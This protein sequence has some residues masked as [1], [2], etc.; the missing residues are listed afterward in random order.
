MLRT[1]QVGDPDGYHDTYIVNIQGTDDTTIA[2]NYEENTRKLGF[3][4]DNIFTEYDQAYISESQLIA[5]SELGAKI[6]V[7]E[8]E[9]DYIIFKK[10]KATILNTKE[11]ITEIETT[12]KDKFYVSTN[13][14]TQFY[15]DGEDNLTKG[16]AKLAMFIYTHGLT[17]VTWNFVDPTKEPLNEKLQP[18]IEYYGNGFSD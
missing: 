7:T 5:L 2:S 13:K 3:T 10:L 14:G 15:I 6:H 17:N 8:N 9:K 4:L 18:L 12:T 1:I 16:V 11:Q